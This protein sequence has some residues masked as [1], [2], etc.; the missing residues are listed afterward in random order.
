MTLIELWQHEL[1][2]PLLLVELDPYG[3]EG[4]DRPHLRR[5]PLLHEH[6]WSFASEQLSIVRDTVGHGQAARVSLK[7]LIA[8]AHATPQLFHGICSL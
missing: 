4:R 8:L 3:T 2:E 7:Q 6:A 5:V 1:C